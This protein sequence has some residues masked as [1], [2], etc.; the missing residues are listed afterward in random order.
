[1]LDTHARKYVDPLIN[2][3]A[4]FLL[5]KGFSPNSITYIA[6]LLG[7]CSSTLVLFNCYVSSAIIL[8][9]SG[10]LDAIDG[11]MARISN[12]KSAW[13]T[14]LDIT[15]D[16]LVECFIIFSIAY[17]F[18]K[19]DMLLV[20]LIGCIVISMTVFLTVGAL[21]ENNGIKSFYYQAGLAERTE[22]FI[23]FT[24]IILFNEKSSVII[25]LFS[26]FIFITAVQR[27]IEAHRL[28][29]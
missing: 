3:S 24:F 5:K 9:V 23:F 22:G 14:I 25:I 15:F 11:A 12:T 1:M 17:K 13:G 26:V 19:L 16:R 4:I 21:F 27:I 18:Q 2:K 8:W 6:L 29:S 28:L 20:V 10:S 7:L